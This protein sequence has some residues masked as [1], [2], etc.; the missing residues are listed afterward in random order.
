M[1]EVIQHLKWSIE[2]GLR[3]LLNQCLGEKPALQ[4]LLKGRQVMDT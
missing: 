3:M 2:T 1:A 4:G